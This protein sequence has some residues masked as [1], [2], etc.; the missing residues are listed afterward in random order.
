[1]KTLHDRPPL[2][3]RL[4]LI[5]FGL[6]IPILLTLP[7]VAAAITGWMV[8]PLRLVGVGHLFWQIMFW[9]SA[10]PLIYTIWL[11]VFLGLCAADVQSRRWYRGLKKVPR[12]TTAEGITK[13][14]P[15]ITLYMRMR[16]V[17]SLPLVEAF[18]LVPGLRWLVLWSY[19]TSVHLAPESYILG[20]I[21]DPDLT[22]IG[23]G[24]VIGTSA[25]IVSHSVTAQPD[26]TMVLVT[27]PIVIGPRAVVGGGSLIALGTTI[28][29]DSF[30]EPM[31]SVAAFTQIPPGEVWGGNPAVFRRKRFEVETAGQGSNT[32][33]IPAN[34]DLERM[35]CR[36][37]ASALRQAESAVPPT[38]SCEDC[39]EWDS[40]GQMAVAS[41]LFSLTGTEIPL[42]E[43]FRLRSVSQIVDYLAARQTPPARQESVVLPTD[44]EL[45]PLRNHKLATQQLAN[46]EASSPVPFHLPTIRVIVA[47][48]FSV[49]PL[50]S[51]L[52]LWCHAF[53]IP[54]EWE[55]AG[56]DQ[57][58]QA[59]LDPDSS[60]RRNVGGVNVIL[61]RVEDL[62]DGGEGR[63][64]S[65]LFAI[66]RFAQ[67][68]P[69]LL[70]VANLPP[71]VSQQR[72]FDGEQTTRVRERWSQSLS[73]MK[74]VQCLD[75][76][77]IVERVGTL[78]AANPEGE[79][80][81]AVPYSADVYAELGIAIA[82]Q[83]RCRRVAPKKVLALDADGVLWGR[84]LGED[85]IDG[86]EL[87]SERAD[88]PYQRF[89][90]V[91]LQLKSRG[92]LLAVVSRNE[93]SDVQQVFDTHPG[94][95][96]RA[97]DIAAWRVNWQPKSQNL[98]EVARELNLGLDSIV[99]VDDDPANQLEVQAALP[100]V[101]VVPLPQE[102][103]L[104]A[105]T[106]ERLWCFD[107]P[108]ATEADAQ[109]TQMIQ[110]EHA[111]Q[112]LRNEAIDLETYLASLN[113]RVVMRLAT[114]GDMPR[115]AQLTQKTNQFNLSLKRRSEAELG[116]LSVEHSI[117]VIEVQ[118]RFGDYGLVGVCILRRPSGDS[119]SI[120]IETLLISCR[121]LGRGV[122]DAT[123]FGI[124]ELARSW[125]GRQLEATLTEGP[126]NQPVFDFLV[127]RGFA[128][129]D[130]NRFSLAADAT[131]TRPGHIE[132]V[133]PLES[134]K[135]VPEK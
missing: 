48:T 61:T 129:A 30:V 55:S 27:A 131:V 105:E 46:R 38:F 34:T 24:A 37:V 66:G 23:Q 58:Q 2:P 73:E 4:T 50:T 104:F 19:S 62:L 133:G 106:L 78:A 114:A 111:R 122:E 21:F 53:G 71:V 83:V 17:Y 88:C 26:G 6:S 25:S 16:F 18:L 39:P 68:Y 117:F 81:A 59:L 7:V 1:M 11:L 51:S 43:C 93:L 20:V 120:E 128:Q 10:A 56:F 86:I 15:V 90:R 64:E 97:S 115:V 91:I 12:V 49:E 125:G 8:S 92:V 41:T 85:G 33:P 36:A 74:G 3:W 72:D 100:E 45:L 80:I 65:L 67:E 14:F 98:R 121:A 127:R 101:T 9:A 57:V 116:G 5:Q 76:A 13:F 84:V 118:D 42:E 79:R 87:G 103:G 47:S 130:T 82:R 77:G 31:S 132:W 134:R 126:R 22:E 99:F 107:A 54:V 69:Q 89:Q 70:V 135:T 109:R 63:G 29:A 52:R 32:A 95:V 94:M 108:S 40:L 123:L 110:Q 44:P 124:L 96:L 35:V 112:S 119:G 75:F 60:F 102:P 113:L 28:G